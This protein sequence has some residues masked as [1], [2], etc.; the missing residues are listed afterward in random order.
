VSLPPA[1]APGRL[2]CRTLQPSDDES[3]SLLCRPADRRIGETT[4][5][6]QTPVVTGAIQ[7]LEP[8]HDHTILEAIIESPFV[9]DQE[10]LSTERGIALNIIMV[11]IALA[12]CATA[13]VYWFRS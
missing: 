8:D 9:Q 3:F 13:A 10:S 4:M 1:L 5:T 7:P 6:S 11:A 2:E 12:I